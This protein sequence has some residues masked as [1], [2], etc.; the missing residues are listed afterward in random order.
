MIWLFDHY[1]AVLGEVVHSVPNFSI[2]NYQ[3]MCT[4]TDRKIAGSFWVWICLMW[5]VNLFIYK[6]LLRQS[7]NKTLSLIIKLIRSQDMNCFIRFYKVYNQT[8]AS[9]QWHGTFANTHSDSVPVTCTEW[10]FQNK[11]PLKTE[12]HA[13]RFARKNCSGCFLF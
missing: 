9:W 13:L 4:T 7:W 11:S 2:R 8:K 6:I 12:K 5:G 10:I 3:N 1:G